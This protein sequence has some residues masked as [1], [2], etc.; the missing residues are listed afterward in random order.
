MLWQSVASH[1]LTL[2]WLMGL[3]D[4]HLTD[5]EYASLREA[6]DTLEDLYAYLVEKHIPHPRS[7]PYEAIPE[8]ERRALLEAVER[9]IAAAWITDE[10][11]IQQIRMELKPPSET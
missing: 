10:E 5:E 2:E 4:V 3:D 1:R 11:V 8:E 9:M 7:V 6:I